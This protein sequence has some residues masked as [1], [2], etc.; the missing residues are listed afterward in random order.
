MI[1]NI[2]Y[3][4]FAATPKGEGYY[5]YLNFTCKVTCPMSHFEKTAELEFEPR[6]P[7]ACSL[8]YCELQ[9]FHHMALT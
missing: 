5:Y 3:I 2:S 9:L 1:L 4:L 7:E 8:I 6:Q